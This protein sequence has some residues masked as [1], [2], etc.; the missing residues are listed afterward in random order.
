MVSRSRS[1]GTGFQYMDMSRCAILQAAWGLHVH[2]T[3]Y[4]H[5]VCL[6]SYAQRFR[7]QLSSTGWKN[8]NIIVTLRLSLLCV[9]C[10]K[11]IS[12]SVHIF[13]IHILFVQR[14]REK[15]LIVSKHTCDAITYDVVMTSGS[16]D[17]NRACVQSNDLIGN[18]LM[19]DFWRTAS[20]VEMRC[21][22][23]ARIDCAN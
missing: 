20:L 10:N 18:R 1:Y 6:H 23:I 7:Q 8:E 13:Y 21:E 22:S 9:G 4:L 2:Y 19:S 16:D 12:R 14:E 15:R 17:F 11:I 3:G 5:V